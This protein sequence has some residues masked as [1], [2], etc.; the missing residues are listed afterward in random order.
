MK[1]KI[2]ILPAVKMVASMN[3]P[4]TGFTLAEPVLATYRIMLSMGK[5]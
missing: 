2:E 5:I 1:I 3:K 4:C